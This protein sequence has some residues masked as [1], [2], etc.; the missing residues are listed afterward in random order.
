MFGITEVKL[1]SKYIDTSTEGSINVSKIY[2]S[3]YSS[4]KK[5]MEFKT[6]TVEAIAQMIDLKDNVDTILYIPK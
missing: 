4:L 2:N 6:K 5:E 1:K 3:V